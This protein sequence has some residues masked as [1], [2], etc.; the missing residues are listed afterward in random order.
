MRREPLL[1]RV[2]GVGAALGDLLAGEEVRWPHPAA[3][4]LLV[5][6]IAERSGDARPHTL[7]VARRGTAV[8]GARFLVEAARRGAVAALIDAASTEREAVRAAA[9]MGVEIL[10]CA[11]TAQAA[12]RAIERLAGEPSRQ[13]RVAAVTGTNGKT[14]TAWLVQRLLEAG[15][16]PCGL[17]STVG[18][19]T[20]DA[21]LRAE[22]TTP[23]RTVLACAMQRMLAAEATACALEA[24]SHALEQGRLA[25]LRVAAALFTNLSG[26]HLDYHGSMEAYVCAKQRL[27]EGLDEQAVAVV[28]A[29]EPVAARMLERCRAGRVVRCSLVGGRGSDALA[30]P[31]EM[32][33]QG[34]RVELLGPWGKVRCS[35]RLFG[36]HNAMNLLQ[37]FAA[38]HALGAAAEAMAQALPAVAPPPGRMEP[39][40]LEDV[41][42]DRLPLVFVDYAHTDDA[43]ARALQAL[44]RVTPAGGRRIVVFGAGGDR[45]ASKR[46][47]MA[48]AA[49][50]GADV[51][52][53][54]SDNP[55]TED[56]QAIVEEV[57]AGLTPVQRREALAIVDRREAIETAIV[58]LARPGDVV[59]VAGKGHEDYQILPDGRGGVV[60]IRFDDREEARRALALRVDGSME[61]AA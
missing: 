12:G 53:V 56:P 33:A 14:T 2:E 16:L 15:G 30:R 54:T 46:P 35:T 51:L 37:A 39:V 41:E 19:D 55:R 24:S 28:N 11:D 32:D 57:L 60:T 9:A 42:Q 23:P 44:A 1:L 13:L 47:R 58:N 17:V 61:S 22:Q 27:F 43:L 26:D 10:R 21:Q 31:L 6:A 38:A 20:R 3:R 36:A 49:V 29:D 8:D 5:R 59:L 45:D 34:M 50:R 18:I 7:F 52:V 40:T 48:Q 25:G 4:K